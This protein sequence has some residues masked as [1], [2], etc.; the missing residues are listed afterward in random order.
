MVFIK[1]LVKT[2]E[3]NEFEIQNREI[4]VLNKGEVLIKV[5][6]CG[7]CG[8]DL[9]AANHDPGYEF[10]PKPIVLGHEISGTITKVKSD[11]DENLLNKRV[12]ITPGI[13]CGQCEACKN[14]DIN[15]CEN[16]SATGLHFDGGMSEFIKAKREQVIPIPDELSLDIAALTEPLSVSI[17]AVCQLGEQIRGKD[18]L[19]QGCGIIGMCTAIVAKNFGANVTLSGLKRDLNTRLKKAQIFDLNIHINDEN[20]Y[21]Q[22]FDYVFECSGSSPAFENSI[23]QIKKGGAAV[24]VALY[25]NQMILSPNILV[26]REIDILGSYASNIK[27]F[28]HA[29]SLLLKQQK[30]FRQLIKLYPLE[31]GANAFLEA[32]NQE[33]LKPVLQI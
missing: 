7:V 23:G 1:S 4:P 31:D 16:I 22:M 20:S 2:I 27:D 11:N 25:K 15:I 32:N 5:D 19:V 30:A 24:L 26:R 6:Y 3:A 12:V 13:V 9:H 29:L 17:H 21:N 28:E 8:S 10:V 33:V 18:V 14:G